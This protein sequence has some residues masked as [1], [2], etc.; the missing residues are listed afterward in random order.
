M[1]TR[2]AR[3]RWSRPMTRSRAALV[4]GTACLMLAGLPLAAQE[5]AAST[6][7]EG[8][9]DVRE[10]LLDVLVTDANGNVILGLEPADFLVEEEGGA[11]D[12]TSATFYSNRRYVEAA[13]IASR[14][15]IQPEEVPVDRYFV[16]FLHDQ[17]RLLPSLTPAYMDLVRRAEAWLHQELLPNDWVAVVRY[18]AKLMVHTDFTT[19]NQRIL[20]ALKDA[21]K[22][23]NPPDTWPSRVEEEA[24]SGPSLLVN[25]PQGRELGERSKRIYSAMETLAEASRYVIGRKNMLLFS[26]GF[27]ELNDFGTWI[28]DARYYDGMMESLNDANVAVYSISVFDGLRAQSAPFG[29]LDARAGG[30]PATVAQAVSAQRAAIGTMENGLSLLSSDTGGEYYFNFLNFSTPLAQILEDNNGYYLLSYESQTPAGE[31]GYRKVTVQTKNPDFEV[32]AREGYR[33]GPG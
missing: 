29:S 11:V 13:D 25:L 21:A 8:T 10:V 19:D 33:Y 20:K 9:V 30:T 14:L 28:P 24:G 27:G 22:G 1:S 18:D 16:I 2:S 32:R 5:P 3:L 4:L 12:V 7:F 23:K 15:G 6:E 31:S 17:R 26:M